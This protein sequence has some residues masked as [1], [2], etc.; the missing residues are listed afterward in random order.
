MM[1]LDGSRL[2]C[3]VPPNQHLGMIH[4]QWRE[5]GEPT[6][7]AIALGVEPAFPLLGG[8]PIPKGMDESEFLG[9]YFGEPTD[10][11][12]AETIPL[13][14]PATAEIVIEGH[15][16]HEDTAMEGPMDE[17][18]GYVG[19]KG[20]PKPVMT[21]SAM[22]WRNDPILPF[23]VAGAPVDENHT[24]WGMPHAAEVLY[25]LREAGFPVSMAWMVLE[26]ANHLMVIA[27][28]PDWHERTGQSS[29]DLSRK[30]GELVFAAKAGFGIPKILLVEDDFDVTDV[31]QVMWAFA[32]RA[33]PSHSEIYFPDEAQNILPVFLT[34][35]EKSVFK[36]T[37]V[38]HNALLADRF[39]VGHRPVRSDLENAWPQDI[40]QRVVARWQDYGYRPDPNGG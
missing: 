9:A 8:M 34:D 12:P 20:S 17:F 5:R 2:A 26:S 4:A 13:D 16:S 33:H 6:P 11:V 28:A 31:S 36:T 1:L 32:S 14:V 10:L 22:T 25:L 3:L 23:A 35:C 37:K 27:L 7:V 39:A 29:A 18:P 40:R 24:C 38:V 30:I 15:I 19:D 21:V